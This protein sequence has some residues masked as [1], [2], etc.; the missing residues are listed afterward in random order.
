MTDTIP[1]TAIPTAPAATPAGGVYNP[2]GTAQ[3]PLQYFLANGGNPVMSQ[4]FLYYLSSL[5]SQ[6]Q[7]QVAANPAQAMQLFVQGVQDPSKQGLSWNGSNWV[8]SSGQAYDSTKDPVYQ[9][10]QQAQADQWN[11][12]FQNSPLWNSG[13]QMNINGLN[14]GNPANPE[15]VTPTSGNM[16]PKVLTPGSTTPANPVTQAGG[17]RLVRGSQG[18][19]IPLSTKPAPVQSGAPG[20]TPTS[21]PATTTPA[22]TVQ[23][24]NSQQAYGGGA[25]YVQ[26]SQTQQA[27]P[28]SAPNAYNQNSGG[29]VN[30]Y[31]QPK[32]AY[33]LRNPGGW[34]F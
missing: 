34:N 3:S 30:P 10:Q 4:Q 26:P 7:S 16:G 21:P 6:L 5:P 1:G 12:M 28:T 29:T 2:W 20:T 8:D 22:T 13:G 15:T 31:A 19:Q 17:D 11:Q 9:A 32:N 14:V 18:G 33:S 23:P 25:Q 24:Q 27:N